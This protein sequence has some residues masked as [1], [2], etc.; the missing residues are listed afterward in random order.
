MKVTKNMYS[1]IRFTCEEKLDNKLHF[2][3][4]LLNRKQ[5]GSIT[6]SVYGRS[7]SGSQYTL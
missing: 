5:N 4:V 6:R 2:S 1:V 7:S 3:N